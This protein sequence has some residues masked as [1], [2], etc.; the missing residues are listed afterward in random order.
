MG[1]MVDTGDHFPKIHKLLVLLNV[2]AMVDVDL[3]DPKTSV[4]RLPNREFLLIHILSS[5]RSSHSHVIFKGRRIHKKS[6]CKIMVS[7]CIQLPV[8]SQSTFC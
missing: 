1:E 3:T 4:K 5:N 7:R 6:R 2:E 8:I